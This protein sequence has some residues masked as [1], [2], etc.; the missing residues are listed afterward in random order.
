MLVT[1]SVWAVPMPP[2]FELDQNSGAVLGFMPCE[3]VSKGT[4]PLGFPSQE[5]QHGGT[6]DT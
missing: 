2:V 5:G 6:V 4:D 1:M 3:V